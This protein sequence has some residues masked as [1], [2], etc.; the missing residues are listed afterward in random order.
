[1]LG[2][3]ISASQYDAG[4]TESPAATLEDAASVAD[5]PATSN[6]SIALESPLAVYMSIEKP[7]AF[8]GGVDKAHIWPRKKCTDAEARDPHNLLALSK[9]LHSCFDGPHRGIPQI[10]IQPLC[11][12]APAA[13]PRAVIYVY[14]RIYSIYRICV[15]MDRAGAYIRDLLNFNIQ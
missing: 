8:C 12:L 13:V 6:H 9:T 1:M 11:S 5:S 15:R 10:A 3:R 7:A 14:E 4:L 2:D